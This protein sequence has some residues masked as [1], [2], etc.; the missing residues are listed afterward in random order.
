MREKTNPKTIQFNDKSILDNDKNV[1]FVE[2]LGGAEQ[3]DKKSHSRFNVQEALATARILED[4]LENV[5]DPQLVTAS[6]IFPYAAQIEYFT[7]NYKDLIN[8]AKKVLKSFE[9]DTV[10]AFQGRETDIVLVN[11]V[12]TRMEKRSFLKDFKRINVSMSRAKDK[13]VVFGSRNLGKLEMDT[14]DGGT[15]QYFKEIIDDIK[16]HGKMIQINQKGEIVNNESHSK[17]KFA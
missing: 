5:I 14:P 12:I 4:I 1:F 6:A 8:R 7:K 2:P 9:L 17:L 11:T 10:D 13:L 3:D 15:R 16:T